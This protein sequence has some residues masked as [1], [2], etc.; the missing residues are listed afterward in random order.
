MK[1]KNIIIGLKDCT[2][3]R[4]I[5]AQHEWESHI[6]NIF[7]IF[8]RNL[9]A[10]APNNLLDVGCGKGDRTIRIAE[11]FNIQSNNIF[12]LDNNDESIIKCE[13]FSM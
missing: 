9:K 10:Y 7:R 2:K 3:Y 8:D 5:G 12:G 13:G 1:D 4:L 11:Y 6:N